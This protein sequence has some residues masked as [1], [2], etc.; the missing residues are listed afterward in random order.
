LRTIAAPRVSNNNQ[1]WSPVVLL[2]LAFALNSADRQYFYSAFPQLRVDL[3]L[4]DAQLG[5]SASVFTWTYAVA[6]PVAGYA[7]DRISR[8]RLV[9]AALLTWSLAT[10]GTSLSRN[11]PQLLF[12]RVAMGITEALFVPAGYALVSTI[13]PGTARSRAFSAFGLAQFFGLAVGGM[14]GGWATQH[15]GWRRGAQSMAA[16]GVIYAFVLTWRLW[17]FDSHPIDPQKNH[18]PLFETLRS[19]RFVLLAI[20]F[21]TFCSML[22]L[23]YVW[24]PTFVHERYR[25]S[26]TQS[27]VTS[28]LYL[29]IGSAL[30]VLAGGI[31]GDR[32]SNKSCTSRLDVAMAGVLCCSPFALLIFSTPS[33]WVLRIV[34]LSFGLSAGVFIANVFACLYDFTDR[35]N[36]SFATGC[37]NMLG[38]AGAGIAILLAGIF[39]NNGGIASLM[40]G[41]SLLADCAAIALFFFA[42][43]RGNRT[44][45]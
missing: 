45:L 38:G 2:A 33:L 15:E 42:R 40:L 26:L 3:S 29:Q 43:Q 7:A 37:L 8:H 35:N 34:T 25:L 20:T 16:L 28:S 19:Y 41:S 11:L 6:M 13:Y 44:L 36:R 23:I 9:I 24:L 32:A 12:W 1:S 27:G 39:K 17:E 22:W 31:L 30:G 10:L 4:T 18:V 21:S 14:Y 5:F